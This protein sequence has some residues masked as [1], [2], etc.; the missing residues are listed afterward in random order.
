MPLPEGRTP[1]TDD[2]M[3]ILL[4]SMAANLADRDAVVSNELRQTADRLSELS[5]K[6]KDRKHWT[7]HE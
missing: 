5:K 7:G 1:L 2:D 4:H 3:I 6:A